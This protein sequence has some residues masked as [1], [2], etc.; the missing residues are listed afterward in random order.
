MPLASQQKPKCLVTGGAGF[1]GR[2]VVDALVPKYDVAIFDVRESG[3]PSARAIL[4]DITK[5]DS[6][7]EACKGQ[8]WT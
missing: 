3:D 8:S 7:T 1:L 4:G 2:H 5:L 6:I